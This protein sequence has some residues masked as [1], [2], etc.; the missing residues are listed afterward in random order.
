MARRITPQEWEAIRADYEV[1]GL[2][3]TEI[4]KNH[5]ISRPSVSLKAK[6]QKWI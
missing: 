6:K 3:T 1:A 2:S 5:A 4:A